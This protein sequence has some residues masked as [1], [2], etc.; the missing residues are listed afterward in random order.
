M[1]VRD[2]DGSSTLLGTAIDQGTAMNGSTKSN[3]ARGT[4]FTATLIFGLLVLVGFL[5]LKVYA[6]NEEIKSLEESR[7]DEELMIQINDGEAR[8]T[9]ESRLSNA[10]D[11]LRRC[12]AKRQKVR[13]RS[14]KSA[15][16]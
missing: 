3:R 2:S 12:H 10:E 16:L 4:V 8:Q 7:D 11:E 5:S 14:A 6:L 15:G 13:R 1:P 9:I